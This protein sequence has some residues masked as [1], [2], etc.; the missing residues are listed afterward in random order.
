MTM[1]LG[2]SLGVAAFARFAPLA[3]FAAET[4]PTIETTEFPDGPVTSPPSVTEPTTVPGMLPLAS[5]RTIV[6]GV[7][8]VVAALASVAPLATFA[9]VTPP[10]KETTEFADGPVTSPPRVTPPTTAPGMLPLLSRKTSVLGVD[11]VVAAFV[12]FTLLATLAAVT[13]PSVETT[14]AV[15]VPVTSPASGPVKEVAE[16][17]TSPVR[18]PVMV[19]ALKFPFESRSTIA[20]NTFAGVA[21]F[22]AVEPLATFAAATPPTVTTVFV[23]DGPVTSPPSVTAPTTAPGMLPFASRKTSVPGVGCVV[24]AFA[25]FTPPATLAALTPPTNE[26]IV[27]ACVPVTSPASGPVKLDDDPLTLPVTLPVTLPLKFPVSIPV[28]VLLPAM[29]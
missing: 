18:L 9:A 5:R 12:R 3:T 15:C 27:A 25:K 16:P 20:S 1:V 7:G 6:L 22:A 21:A 26:T 4:P 11:S 24:A 17:L 10:T 8:S 19:P 14:V 13:P 23:P 29:I 2:V 28:K